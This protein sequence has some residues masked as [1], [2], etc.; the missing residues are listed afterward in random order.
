M[1]DNIMTKGMWIWSL[2]SEQQTVISRLQ[3]R[4]QS[5]H[6]SILQKIE[7]SIK[8]KTSLVYKLTHTNP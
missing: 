7:Q 5:K 8:P 2:L 3:Y 6:I 4:G 1:L